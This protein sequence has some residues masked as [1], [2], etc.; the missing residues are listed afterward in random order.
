M[1]IYISADIEGV[2]GIAHWD[3]AEKNAADW[4]AYRLTMTREVAAACKGALAAGAREVTVKDA[5]GSGRNILAERL[6][7]QTRL[8]RGWSGH[9]FSMVQD[10]DSSHA[11]IAMIGYHAPAG[12]PANP[13][14]HTMSTRYAEVRLNGAIASEFMLNSYSTIWSGVPVAFFSGDAGLCQLAGELFPGLETV[15]TNSGVGRSVTAAHPKQLR[16]QIRKGVEKALKYPPALQRL[17]AHFCMDIVFRHHGDAY[18]A[19][20]F[21]GASQTGASA[22]RYEADDFFEIMRFLHFV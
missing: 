4:A 1:K 15:A 8:I 5:H 6:P 20:F 17:P 2:A 21:P 9:P 3:E 10:I 14:S 22:V 13:L 7:R 19:G 11:A 12:S 18:N 16:K